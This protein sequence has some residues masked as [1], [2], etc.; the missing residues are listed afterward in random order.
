MVVISLCAAS[1]FVQHPTVC[2]RMYARMH[3]CVL[4]SATS[5]VRSR[6]RHHDDLCGPFQLWSMFDI[7]LY[8][9]VLRAGS[10]DIHGVLS[11]YL[12]RKT[13]C[14]VPFPLA[15]PCIDLICLTLWLSVLFCS[16]LSF[17]VSFCVM[18]Y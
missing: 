15:P 7:S 13:G 8:R 14:F 1:L 11:I 12:D 17:L 4:G 10:F 5:A 2:E 6:G 3:A 18:L 9:T 16:A